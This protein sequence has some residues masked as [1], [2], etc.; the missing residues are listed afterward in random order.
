MEAGQ[1]LVEQLK[2]RLSTAENTLITSRQ[3]LESLTAERN[4]AE[5]AL[6]KQEE[7][8]NALRDGLQRLET[9]VQQRML[10]EEEAD[11]RAETGTQRRQETTFRILAATSELAELHLGSEQ[12]LTTI[13]T[14]SRE[15]DTL[16]ANRA[17]VAARESELATQ[18]REFATRLHE[19][20]MEQG[21]LNHQ[22]ETTAARI[23]DEFQFPLL[24][25]VESGV[26]AMAAHVIPPLTE[27]ET[28]PEAED[29]AEDA[30]AADADELS[31][32]EDLAATDD[33]EDED[34][35]LEDDDG[36][37][38]EADDEWDEDDEDDEDTEDEDEF[39]DEEAFDE[40]DAIAEAS[41]EDIES[42]DDETTEPEEDTPVEDEAPKLSAVEQL[43]D[44]EFE[45]L[46]AELEERV[47]RLR[48]RLR[49]MGNVS[50]ESLENL[51][52]L[53]GRFGGP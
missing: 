12:I 6:G 14:E 46:R 39:N 45:E 23:E 21:T 53:E 18:R 30:E 22:L 51:E 3:Q 50:T 2:E 37:A 48:R 1:T 40:D 26:S 41:E 10:Q 52:E 47:E 31:E 16:K 25:A 43:D 9:D 32:P 38:A 15:L 24:D 20:E 29:I 17:G 35:E 19:V 11:R 42:D 49:N 33:E 44:E 27:V 7:R 5:I 8:F 34:E 4:Q 36:V 13:R 28:E